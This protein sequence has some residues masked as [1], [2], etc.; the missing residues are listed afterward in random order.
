VASA[1]PIPP[2]CAL[3]LGDRSSPS[4]VTRGLFPGFK[5]SRGVT[6]AALPKMFLKG[7]Q[8]GFPKR[9]VILLEFSKKE[10]LATWSHVLVAA[11]LPK[12]PVCALK[13]GD[14]SSPPVV[15]RGLSAGL[16]HARSVSAAAPPVSLRWVPRQFLEKR[17]Q[18]REPMVTGS[19][20]FV[21]TALPKTPICAPKLGDR[22]SPSGDPR[23]LSP[24]LRRSRSVTISIYSIMFSHLIPSVLIVQT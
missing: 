9:G 7:C 18:R 22:S 15:A 10:S 2:I 21:A 17:A 20:V 14:R 19:H 5:R 11:A 6:A 4:G 1:P 13:L 16:R 8:D 23:G 3:K 24:G 12:N